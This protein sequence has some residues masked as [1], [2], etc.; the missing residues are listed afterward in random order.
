MIRERASLLRYNFFACIVFLHGFVQNF[1]QYEY[2]NNK[3]KQQQN[4]NLK[5][6]LVVRKH[7]PGMQSASYT[8]IYIYTHTDG[9]TDR[10]I[11]THISL[12]LG[13]WL[14]AKECWWTESKFLAGVYTTWTDTRGI[15]FP[16]DKNKDCSQNVTLLAVQPLDAVAS[17]TKVLLN[18]FA[19]KY[20][21]ISVWRFQSE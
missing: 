9:R 1:Y 4:V 6:L 8:Y 2:S 17:P 18:S 10:Q 11:H 15:R 13:S 7:Y 5:L 16:Q 20:L 3:A 19:V 14:R 12:S 21:D